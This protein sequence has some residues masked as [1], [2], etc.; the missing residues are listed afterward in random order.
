[1]REGGLELAL[2]NLL[3]RHGYDSLE[4]VRAEEARSALRRVL[5]R[6]GFTPTAG[7]EA[8]LAACVDRAALDAWVDAAVT[9]ASA[10]EALG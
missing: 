1:M 7:E 10:A 2:R 9:A 3:Q 4:A 6:R 8:R 5:A